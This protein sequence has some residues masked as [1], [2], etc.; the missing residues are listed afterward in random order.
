MTGGDGAD[1]IEGGSGTDFTL[2]GSGLDTFDFNVGY[3]I[4]TTSL[5]F[6]IMSIQFKLM[7]LYG[8]ADAAAVIAS[9]S[10]SGGDAMK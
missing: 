9:T 10:V 5:I 3:R 8:F 4:L 1:L 2:C 6:K 7:G